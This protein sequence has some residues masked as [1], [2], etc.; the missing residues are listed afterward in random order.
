MPKIK[1]LIDEEI[2]KKLEELSREVEASAVKQEHNN[3]SS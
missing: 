1:D 3:S 2:L